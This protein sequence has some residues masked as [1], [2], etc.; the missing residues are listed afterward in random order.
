MQQSGVQAMEA[1]VGCGLGAAGRGSNYKG[2]Y[3]LESGDGWNGPPRAPTSG[4]ASL[5]GKAD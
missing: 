5:G 4:V 1:K 3:L 2:D